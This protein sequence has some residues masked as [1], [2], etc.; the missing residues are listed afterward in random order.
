MY[1]CM[2]EPIYY[3]TDRVMISRHRTGSQNLK[4]ETGRWTRIPPPPPETIDTVN[5][6]P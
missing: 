4:I 1:V 2:Y 3:E 5:V 6:D